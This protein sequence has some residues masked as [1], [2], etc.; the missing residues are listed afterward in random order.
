M[1]KSDEAN[2]H[3]DNQNQPISFIA[4]IL[5][6][7]TLQVAIIIAALKMWRIWLILHPTKAND[8]TI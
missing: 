4:I 3:L 1:Q 6:Y 7:N 5:H 2:K 8:V